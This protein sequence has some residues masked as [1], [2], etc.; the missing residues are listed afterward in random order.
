MDDSNK[1]D[2]HN[3][4]GELVADLALPDGWE[5]GQ[6]PQRPSYL[7]AS[8]FFLSDRDKRVAITLREPAKKTYDFMDPQ[9]NHFLQMLRRPAHELSDTEMMNIHLLLEQAGW[10]AKFKRDWA[11]TT[12]VPPH[13]I[14]QLQGVW[15]AERIKSR[16]II[17]DTT[18]D[19]ANYV[20]EVW[21]IAPTEIFD[22]YAAE[23]ERIF[24][25]FRWNVDM[26]DVTNY[27]WASS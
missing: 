23:A 6:K 13:N 2:I 8:R 20:Q 24:S 19:T 10:P 12:F 18:F 14:L 15:V 26:E 25:S 22:V 16:A 17:L 4:R 1:I 9:Q 11:R 3:Q 27:P 7:L 21:F 5:R